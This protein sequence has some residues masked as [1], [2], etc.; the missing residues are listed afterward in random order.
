[1]IWSYVNGSW[2]DV[3]DNGGIL[4]EITVVVHYQNKSLWNCEIIK[5][6]A[7]N[8]PWQSRLQCTASQP[9]SIE[10]GWMLSQTPSRF[11]PTRL[12][13]SDLILVDPSWSYDL[14]YVRQRWMRSLL[15]S[16]EFRRVWHRWGSNIMLVTDRWTKKIILPDNF[17]CVSRV[18][19]FQCQK[20]ITRIE[21][22]NCWFID[23]STTTTYREHFSWWDRYN[24][25]DSMYFQV[26]ISSNLMV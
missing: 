9:E 23:L 19:S 7:K 15:R 26:P 11:D 24:S 22:F 13:W 18:L 21:S 8:K 25:S 5:L 16:D 1:M 20:W 3:D 6:F 14:S 4:E 2:W 10:W 17:L 12:D